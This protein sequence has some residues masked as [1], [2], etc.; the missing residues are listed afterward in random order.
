MV[1]EWFRTSSEL[2]PDVPVSDPCYNHPSPGLKMPDPNI[3]DCNPDYC[4]PDY[5]NLDYGNRADRA[6][7]ISPDRCSLSS[8]RLR[9]TSAF[10]LI[11]SSASVRSG[12]KATLHPA[13]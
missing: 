3:G 8:S 9:N 1:R 5:S 13:S 2:V 12:T 11:S 6:P 4:N 10:D 7:P